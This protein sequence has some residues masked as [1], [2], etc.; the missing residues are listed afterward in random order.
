MRRFIKKRKYSVPTWGISQKSSGKV[1]PIG[2]CSPETLASF[3]LLGNVP[4]LFR[5]VFPNRGKLKK[6]IWRTF[7]TRGRYF[8]E[9]IEVCTPSNYDSGIVNRESSE[10]KTVYFPLFIGI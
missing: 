10:S 1:S 2:D 4:K 6:K 3:P 9:K 8:R 5:Q 7:P